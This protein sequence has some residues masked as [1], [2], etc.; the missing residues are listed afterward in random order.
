MKEMSEILKAAIFDVFE[1][2]YYVFLE[3][4]N[5]DCSDYAMGSAIKF[6]GPMQGELTLHFSEGL[7]KTM[8]H[9]LLGLE[10]DGITEQD[11]DDCVKEAAN[12]ICGNFLAKLDQ[13]KV[14]DL[15]IPIFIRRPAGFRRDNNSC[16][17][18]FD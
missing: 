12:M 11:I 4:L 6:D 2:M 14:F 1:R 18:C 5:D 3:P 8:V 16:S 15:S 10:T 17:L 9:N 13:T 7:A